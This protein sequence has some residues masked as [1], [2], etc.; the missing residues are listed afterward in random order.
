LFPLC[1]PARAAARFARALS[2]ELLEP[3]TLLAAAV[4]TLQVV[5]FPLPAGGVELR[6]GGTWAD[7]RIGIAAGPGGVVVRDDAAGASATF[8]GAYRFVGVY[9]GGGDDAVAVDPSL[10]LPVSLHGDAGN[11]TLAGGSGNDNLYGGDGDDVL[12]G[13]AG[14]DVLVTLGGG[15]ADLAF[16]G[17]GADTF[18]ADAARRA[19]PVLDLSLEDLMT[20]GYHRV[21]SF[22]ASPSLPAA[23]RAAAKLVT[24]DGADLPDPPGDPAFPYERFSDYP[25]FSDRGPTGSD[26]VQ[27]FTGDCYLMSVF[28]SVADLNPGRIRQSVVDLGDGTYAVQFGKG[29]ARKT[30]RVDGDLPAWPGDGMPA[31]AGLGVGGSMWV[32]VMEKAYATYRRGGQGYAGLDTGWMKES[33]AA[34]GVSSRSVRAR[35]DTGLMQYLQSE[36]L[37]GRSVTFATV[38][39][40]AGTPLVGLHAYAVVGVDADAA[41]NLVGLRLRNPWGVDGAGND[42][43]D[44]GYVTITPQQALAS[45]MGVVSAAA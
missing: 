27:G 25:L 7:D 31:Y 30:V 37:Q 21:G 41:G 35:T 40:P 3:R 5:E 1:R 15:T 16:G 22:F 28:M 43:A 23:Q 14:D 29:R 18:W 11:D 4:G 44:D 36:L 19:D 9:A 12:D 17:A 6:V 42:G 10:A 13:G 39:P 2:P 26:V 33:Y 34:L 32:A 45:L 38:E 24:L 20:G 8:T